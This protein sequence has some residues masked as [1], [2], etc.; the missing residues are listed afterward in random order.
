LILEFLG[1]SSK[2]ITHLGRFVEEANQY[3]QGV[4]DAELHWW[5]H[6]SHNPEDGNYLYF[7][8]TPRIL[9]IGEGGNGRCIDDFVVPGWLLF[10]HYQKFRWM[11]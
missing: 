7:V 5:T 10:R 2:V 9:A 1:I 4:S 8:P 3:K 6:R 11:I